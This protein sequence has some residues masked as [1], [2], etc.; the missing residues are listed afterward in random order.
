MRMS[1]RA[2][3]TF[4]RARAESARSPR[5]AHRLAVV[6]AG[7]IT[8]HRLRQRAYGLLVICAR[9]LSSK[10]PRPTFPCVVPNRQQVKISHCKP[11]RHL[12]RKIPASLSTA[13]SRALLLA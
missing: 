1:I 3:R 11:F 8:A 2:S 10:I 4:A 13:A 5:A 6:D 7:E 12:A 9:H